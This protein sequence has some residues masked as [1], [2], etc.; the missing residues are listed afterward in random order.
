MSSRLNK[1]VR[2]YAHH[3]GL[4]WQAGLADEQRVLF[5]VYNKEEE[6]KLRAR[7]EEFRVASEAAGHAWLLLDITNAFAEW[8]AAEEYRDA[9][10]TDPNDLIG[11][12]PD[13]AHEVLEGL[14]QQ[15]LSATEQTQVALLGSGTLFGF[16]SVAGFVKTLS[17]YVPGRLL[18]FFPGE[19]ID[20]TYRLLDARDGWGYLA[21]AL[22]A[23][24]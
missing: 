24:N 20:N 14:Q 15:L 10:F 4:P 1:L 5:A 11:N 2:N 6:L 19:Y 3:I 22:T 13:F 8:M 12:Y 17:A 18:V 21:T 9:Y 23:D 16:T 7:T